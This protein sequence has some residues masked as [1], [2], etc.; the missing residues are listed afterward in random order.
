MTAPEFLQN[1]F[2]LT[3]TSPQGEVAA[4]TYAEAGLG[5]GTRPWWPPLV[6]VWLEG[7]I[8]PERWAGNQAWNDARELLATLHADYLAH[9]PE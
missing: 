6:D 9:L 1:L 5:L 7:P 3:A 8:P 2:A 4:L